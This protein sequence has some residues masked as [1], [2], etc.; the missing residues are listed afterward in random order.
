MNKRPFP[1]SAET[2]D[3]DADSSEISKPATK[4]IRIDDSCKSSYSDKCI[5]V[6]TEKEPNNSIVEVK[7]VS[8]DKEII[9]ISSSSTKLP[10]PNLEPT[11]RNSSSPNSYNSTT[12][13]GESSNVVVSNDRPTLPPPIPSN[14]STEPTSSSNDEIALDSHL[15]K[16]TLTNEIFDESDSLNSSNIPAN[17]LEPNVTPST[18]SEP[19]LRRLPLQGILKVAGHK[20]KI[21]RSLIFNGVT[22]YYFRRSQGFTC[23]P[24]QGG[25]TLGME[26]THTFYRNFT[27]ESHAEER[28]RAHRE[29]LV[30]QK[31][32]AKMNKHSS[33]S[34]SED[35]SYDDLS[36]FSDIDLEN[37]NCYFLQPVPIKQ[38]RALLRASGVRKIETS[39][40]EE[41]R[42]IRI[43]R[44]FCGCN[45]QVF[46]NPE[47]CACHQAGI[48][49]QVDRMSF[50]CG[51][52]REGCGNSSGRIEFNPVRV[53]THFLKTIMKL[54]MEK[55]PSVRR[56]LAF[57]CASHFHS[58]L[59]HL[60]FVP[61]PFSLANI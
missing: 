51:C 2:R 11:S 53:R 27:L 23:V 5:Q 14:D 39:E 32:F 36:D 13:S 38:R 58:E 48:S 55:K 44:E 50:P 8:T 28:K 34:E 22:V 20:P 12:D 49:C 21:K 17:K 31:R 47:L 25:S 1:E 29:I 15:N 40:K 57:S 37:D 60:F 33:T 59:N 24:S 26:N 35:D 56:R 54:E 41:C 45:C 6:D 30:R 7:G 16:P 10:Q 9:I 18:S 52:T 3:T 4:I 46:C 61:F 42:D 43:S 19:D